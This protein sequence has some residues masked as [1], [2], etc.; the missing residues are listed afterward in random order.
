MSFAATK[1]SVSEIETFRFTIFIIDMKI[2][3]ISIARSH[4]LTD[5]FE[6]ELMN[7]RFLIFSAANY[8][9]YTWHINNNVL[10]NC[11]KSFFI[12]EAWKKFFSEWKMMMYAE[13]ERE[14]LQLWNEF[15]DRYNASHDECVRYL[16]DIYIR[17]YRRRFVKCYTNQILHFDITVTSRDEKAHAVL[18]RQLESF[19][20]NLKTVI[21]EINLLLINEQRNYL[22]D[23]NDA[24]L[25]YSI[26]LRK[27]VFD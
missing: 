23:I 11:K 16:Y 19:I 4:W 18:K 20:D 26:E 8:L 22:I 27:L 13:S 3:N 15:S 5:W 9:L 2:D 24:K 12:K 1:T 10:I 14:Y 17:N 21:D 7:D 6:K 25:R